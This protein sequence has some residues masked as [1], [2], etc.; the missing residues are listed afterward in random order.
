MML[1]ISTELSKQQ[2]KKKRR[3]EEGRKGRKK[4]NGNGNQTD[5]DHWRLTKQHSWFSRISF[6]KHY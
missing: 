1:M 3:K 6:N 4:E 5:K 2:K